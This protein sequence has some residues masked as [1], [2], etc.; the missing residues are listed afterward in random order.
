MD[1][2]DLA[3]LWQRGAKF[4]F[5]RPRQE[6]RAGDLY[7]AGYLEREW[8]VYRVTGGGKSQEARW[9]YR[10]SEKGKGVLKAQAEVK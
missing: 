8:R 2:H 1:R 9:A 7:R 5:L 3:L 6:D 4:A 10:L